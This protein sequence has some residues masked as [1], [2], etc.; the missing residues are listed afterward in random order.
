MSSLSCI[1]GVCAAAE[2]SAPAIHNSIG[3]S[4]VRIEPGE[5]MMGAG[6]APLPLEVAGKPWRVNGDFDEKPVHKVRISR[7][8]YMGATEVTN[9]QYEQFDP[10]HRK[11]RGL[12]GFS[13]GDHEAVVCVSWHDAVRFCQWLS[14]KE[15][16][17]YRLPTE[18]EWEYACRAGTT[19]PFHTGDTLPRAYQKNQREVWFPQSKRDF[20]AL[21]VGLTPPNAWG[22]HDMHGNVE[23][24][25]HDWYGPYTS[26]AQVD[27]VGYADGDFKV[28]RGGSHST[29][30]Y[31]LRSANRIGTLPEDRSWL[32]GFRV[33][34]GELPETKPLSRPEPPLHQRNVKQTIP[35]DLAE[36][37]DPSKP[38]FAG[39]KKY[40]EIR[41]GSYGPMF[42]SHNHDPAI[43]ECPNGDLL[44]V[45]YS[46]V[47]E[48]GR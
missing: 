4:L 36:G 39:P 12:Y 16:R 11:Q 30:I 1:A 5:F 26:A 15:G 44:A 46:C 23:E 42:S 21:T 8:F 19:T 7:A 35:K 13:K 47:Q 27:P 10:E 14:K 33:V 2:G 40:V 34:M 6:K 9:L 3:M 45:W 24:W 43:V 32:I 25:C 22:L 18:A 38:Y 28:T 31:Y 41:P 20:V 37:P 17:P 48:P 29:L